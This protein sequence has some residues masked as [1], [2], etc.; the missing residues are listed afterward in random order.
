MFQPDLDAAP[1][2][3]CAL[4]STHAA[5]AVMTHQDMPKQIYKEEVCL[6]LVISLHF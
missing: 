3:L 4:G 1:V 6:Y 5:L 2:V